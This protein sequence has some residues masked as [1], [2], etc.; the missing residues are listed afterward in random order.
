M[1]QT[2]N[3]KVHL[4]S[5]ECWMNAK[6]NNNSQLHKYALY[7]NDSAKVNKETGS[8]PSVALDHVNLHGRPGYGLSD[9]YLIDTYSALRN[10]KEGMTRDRCPIQLN[11]RTFKGG[12]RLTGKTGDIN[13]ELDVLSGS[14]TRLIPVF[15]NDAEKNTNEFRGCNKS[16]M[17]QSMNNFMPLLDCIKEVQKP[18][19]IVPSW[20]R[21]GDDTRSYVNKVKFNRCNV[22]RKLI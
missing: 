22:D 2:Y 10:N 14:D 16:I 9:D 7:Y 15:A 21:G 1:D 11:T 4:N 13:K 17:E 19:H 12:P 5:D 8:F 6:D 3:A 18:E 20:T